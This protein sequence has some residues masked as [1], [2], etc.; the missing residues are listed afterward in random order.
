MAEQEIFPCV[1]S[2]QDA[3]IYYNNITKLFLGIRSM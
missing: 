1:L 2:G 3:G